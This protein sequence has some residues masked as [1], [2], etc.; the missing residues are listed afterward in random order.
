MNIFAW[1]RRPLEYVI[2]GNRQEF[3]DYNREQRGTLFRHICVHSNKDLIG[4]RNPDI[5]F[6][7]TWQNRIDIEELLFEIQHISCGCEVHLTSH[8]SSSIA[9]SD[10]PM[11]LDD[12]RRAVHLLQGAENRHPRSDGNIFM[13]DGAS[14]VG[15]PIRFSGTLP[16][17]EGVNEVSYVS[18][19]GAT[20][21]MGFDMGTW[22]MGF[23]MGSSKV[24]TEPVPEELETEPDAEDDNSLK[25]EEYENE[26]GR[27]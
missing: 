17:T 12:L 19:D 22:M 26:S 25:M 16:A 6:I 9:T 1:Q 5:V 8:E 27:N 20:W 14:W 15:G 4:I 24:Q 23:D 3:D 7:G 13:F 21:M 11:T 10:Q 2:A 18:F